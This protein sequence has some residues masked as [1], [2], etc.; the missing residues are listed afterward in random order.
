MKNNGKKVKTSRYMLEAL[1]NGEK[2]YYTGMEGGEI[3]SVSNKKEAYTL[4]MFQK[5]KAMA[6][7]EFVR[8]EK[9]SKVSFVMVEIKSK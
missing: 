8:D 9:E 5:S 1:V 3:K 2:A 4:I 7:G 6:T